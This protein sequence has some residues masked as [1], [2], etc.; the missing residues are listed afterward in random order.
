VIRLYV[1]RVRYQDDHLEDLNMG[2]DGGGESKKPAQKQR[3]AE[4]RYSQARIPRAGTDL[5]Y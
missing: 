3:G 4:T 2:N 1:I 5:G